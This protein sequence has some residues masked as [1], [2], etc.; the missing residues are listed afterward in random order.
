MNKKWIKV[1]TVLVV[2]TA[3]ASAHAQLGVDST[4][5]PAA[6]AQ[7]QA[8][9]QQVQAEAERRKL[10]STQG[11]PPNLEGLPSTYAAAGKVG[12]A[13][14]AETNQQILAELIKI[15]TTLK[16]LLDFERMKF[17]ATSH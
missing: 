12:A 15:D 7:V 4:A 16:Q 8:V 17:S 14:S 6:I 11:L 10:S 5:L 13:S 1:V 9:T 3:G 2:L